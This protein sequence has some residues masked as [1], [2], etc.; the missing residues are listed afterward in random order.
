MLTTF[1]YRNTA[2]IHRKKCSGL[3]IGLA[4]HCVVILG[5]ITVG[6]FTLSFIPQ[7]SAQE[8]RHSAGTAF[9]PIDSWVYP[10][11]DRL[12][13]LGFTPTALTGLRPWTRVE[14]ARLVRQVD[15]KMR[16]GYSNATARELLGALE[17]E[18]APEIQVAA[19]AEL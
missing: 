9:V 10:A 5:L 14:C 4:R 19:F 2:V 6:I 8:T 3:C 1:S 17:Q 11:F 16:T 12:G 7:A 13:A 18:F 15:A